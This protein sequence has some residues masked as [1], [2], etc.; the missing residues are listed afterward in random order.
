MNMVNQNPFPEII[1][2]NVV[3]TIDLCTNLNLEKITSKLNNYCKCIHGK[4]GIISAV[5]MEL[6]NPKATAMIYKTGKIN[7]FGAKN[8]LSALKAFHLIIKSLKKIG[9]PFTTK[10]YRIT[11][12]VGTCYLNFGIDLK[13]FSSKLL[14]IDTKNKISQITKDRY[15]YD[16]D[17]FPALI[18]YMNEPRITI[19]IF[20]KG[21]INFVGAQKK[22]DINKVLG[23]IY[24]I[25]LNYKMNDIEQNKE[26]DQTA[27]NFNNI[28]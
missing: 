5:K 20:S 17:V 9:Y 22:M 1:T 24:P 25:L 7:I 4:S 18:Y 6:K 12:I 15:S 2:S 23:E 16:C 8:E 26:K 19:K 27:I 13:K 3:S 14:E 10:T 21:I 11:N 28:K